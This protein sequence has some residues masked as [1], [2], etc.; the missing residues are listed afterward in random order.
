MPS[1]SFVCFSDNCAGY[2]F[3]KIV[4]AFD[5]VA[6]CPRCGTMAKFDYASVSA[7]FHG[8]TEKVQ[9]YFNKNIDPKSVENRRK[10]NNE[11][12]RKYEM[13]DMIAKFGIN[14]LKNH[15]MIK[16]GR[17]RGDNE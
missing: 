10:S 15:P 2:G 17:V 7:G 11:H 6:S 12:T 4:G 8:T 3:S 9:K 5:K 13:D 1:K 14:D 16:N